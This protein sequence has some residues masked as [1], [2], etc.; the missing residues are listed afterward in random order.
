VP[1]K[2]WQL[3]GPASREQ[4]TC[5]DNSQEQWKIINPDYQYRCLTAED[6][7]N[8][9]QRASYYKPGLLKTYNA[10]RNDQVLHA[11]LVRYLI[12]FVE[13]GVYTDKGTQPVRP[14]QD[15]VPPD[16]RGSAN[17]VLII[18]PDKGLR[19]L[20]EPFAMGLAPFAVMVKP[21]HPL[22]NLV[23]ESLQKAV[24]D[25]LKTPETKAGLPQI[26]FEDL[27]SLTGPLLLIKS[28]L[29]YL[30]E[31]TGSK[32]G[33]EEI[34]SITAPTLIADILILP[35]GKLSSG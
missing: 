12:L 33:G 10:I 32:I 2:I 19:T 26:S 22:L 13:G 6:Q 4:R 30:S 8:F 3:A 34:S 35:I 18:E 15:W 20:W 25:F 11:E 29:R 31:R 27:K 9:V 28:V 1:K 5:I 14:I 24:M 21:H 17:V 16:F 7:Y 23:V